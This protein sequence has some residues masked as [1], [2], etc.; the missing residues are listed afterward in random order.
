MRRRLFFLARK[1]RMRVV[2]E[3]G[4]PYAG[5]GDLEVPLLPLY[6]NR[7][8]KTGCMPLETGQLQN[9]IAVLLLLLLLLL[10]PLLVVVVG[11]F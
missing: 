10:L 9:A 8:H 4:R 3:T 7:S 2:W 5:R 1:K 6:G 11:N